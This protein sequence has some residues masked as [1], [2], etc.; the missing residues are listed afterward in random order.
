ME[1]EYIG[2][3]REH[4]VYLSATH[5]EIV[6]KK[7]KNLTTLATKLLWNGPEIIRTEL[8]EAHNLVVNTPV[9][10]PHTRVLSLNDSYVIAQQY[11]Q[12]DNS[13]DIRSILLNSGLDS[14]VVEYDL[15]PSNFS[16]HQNIVYWLDPTRG[17]IGRLFERF[18]I[19]K[20]PTYRKIRRFTKNILG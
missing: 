19:M 1:R 9:E 11:I 10:I 8:Q 13:A 15:N 14:L 2:E 17:Q 7:P 20:L 6:L 16:S 12:E 18:H 4:T 5:P 3:G